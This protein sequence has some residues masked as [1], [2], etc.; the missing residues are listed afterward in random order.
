MV[1]E[2]LKFKTVYFVTSLHRTILN[3]VITTLCH[4]HINKQESRNAF[5]FLKIKSGDCQFFFILTVFILY[6]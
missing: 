4:K 5:E 1:Y 3:I 2:K 6:F